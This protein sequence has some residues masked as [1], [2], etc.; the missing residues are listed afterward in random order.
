M[1]DQIVWSETHENRRE[2]RQIGTPEES[3]CIYIEE[4]AY[5]RLH[6]DTRGEKRVFLLLG[7]NEKAENGYITVVEAVVELQQMTFD[8]LMP[9]WTSRIWNIG[10]REI[11]NKYERMVIVGWALD[12]RGHMPVLTQDIEAIQREQFGGVRQIFLLMD[13]LELEETFY[14]NCNNHLRRQH[15]FW[16]YKGE[17]AAAQEDWQ[18]QGEDEYEERMTN[19]MRYRQGRYREERYR[20][21]RYASERKKEYRRERNVGEP[22]EDDVKLYVPKKKKDVEPEKASSSDIGAVGV[23]AAILLLIAIIGTGIYQNRVSAEKLEKAMETLRTIG[24]EEEE[25][26]TQTEESKYI[27]IEKSNPGSL[28]DSQTVDD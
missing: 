11:R 27:R 2:V 22:P 24:V 16:V 14:R 10:F 9:E 18:D 25:E 15:G 7:H 12:L 6:K 5:K 23:V 21:E 17:V 19:E 20:D 1:T 13:S 4:R 3:D 26:V 28:F 8:H